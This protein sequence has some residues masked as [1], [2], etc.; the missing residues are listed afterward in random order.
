MIK[1]LKGFYDIEN[2]GVRNFR[3]MQKNAEI[4]INEYDLGEDNYFLKFDVAADKETKLIIS[5]DKI[6]EINLIPG[7]QT[8]FIP[9]EKICDIKNKKITFKSD[10]YLNVANDNRELSL[11]IS[12][13][14]IIEKKYI[15]KFILE[16]GFYNKE[17]DGRRDFYW[18]KNKALLGL[19]L[20]NV[21]ID[22]YLLLE[23]CSTCDFE[24]IDFTIESNNYRKTIKLI[25]GWQCVGIS[26]IKLNL[27]NNGVNFISFICNWR[28]RLEKDNRELSVMISN[29]RIKKPNKF[30]LNSIKMHDSLFKEIVCD[31]KAWCFSCDT[32]AIC[33][34]RCAYCC[35]DTE[36]RKHKNS[37]KGIEKI[38]NQIIEYLPYAS[39]IQPYLSGEPLCRNDMWYV[40]EVADKVR[41]LYPMRE[42]E[43]STNGLLID[44]KM[45]EKIIDSNITSL[46]ISIN[47][48]TEKTY[49]RIQGGDF[50]RLIK[51]LK[52]LSSLKKERNKKSL[53]ISYSYVVMRENIEELPDFIRL[54]SQLEADSVQ[55]WPLNSNSMEMEKRQMTN[56]FIFYYKQQNLVFYPNITK[57]KLKESKEIANE[58]NLNIGDLPCYRFDFNEQKDISYPI[59]I[60]EFDSFFYNDY[61]GYNININGSKN[62]V[63]INKYK[64]CYYPWTYYYIATDGSFAPCLHLIY[65]GGIGNILEEGIEGVWN[66]KIMQELRRCIIEG[67]VHPMCKNAQ[68]PFI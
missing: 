29:I 12:N 56:D 58:L 5:T 26:L 61:I 43:F 32:S 42:I 53:N 55:I 54:A 62:I 2:D 45:A 8:K 24:C 49:K 51:N 16:N 27:K 3:W 14:N 68:C 25:P 57:A 60:E 31:T 30:E 19:N 64:K 63:D 17:N 18:I 37:P 47:A 7:W 10:N 36:I 46:L 9:L 33:N 40:L 66:N 4:E 6:L 34:L 48:A 50:N 52:Y 28:N 67:K 15:P 65:K 1:Y 21:N 38:K 59:S 11:M 39:K 23:V 13:I 44:E 41:D 20:T 22:D 35:L